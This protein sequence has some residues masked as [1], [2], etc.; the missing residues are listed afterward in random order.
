MLTR[1]SWC[2]GHE[3]DQH[4][5]DTEW[6]VPAYDDRYLF[7]MLTL[8]GAQAGL[9]WRTVLNKR[10][11]YRAALDNF[12]PT[13]IVDYDEAKLE[14]LLQ[15][16]GLIRNKLKIRSLPRNARA[17]LDIQ[18]A[19]GSFAAYIWQFVDGQPII[20]HYKNIE[21]APASTP[22]SDQMSKALKKQGFTFVGSTI[23]YAYM[24]AVGMVNDHTT[25]CYRHEAVQQHAND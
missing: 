21:A 1:C 5:H 14:A 7:E 6:G 25:D 10:E 17:F 3:L 12:N 23:C 22:I 9:S 15:N 11:N 4:Y 20:N 8:E 19:H 16:A 2:L 24:Q 18:S 13:L